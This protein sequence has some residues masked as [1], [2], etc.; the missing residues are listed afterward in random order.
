[1]NKKAF[2]LIEL[3]AVIV[4][5]AIIL[6]IAIPA[7]SSI[8]EN[9]RYAAFVQ[10]KSNIVSAAKLYAST[11]EEELPKNIGER[12]FINLQKL[13]DANLVTNSIVDTRTG[14]TITDGDIAVEKISPL[15]FKYTFI[16]S[17]IIKQGLVLWLEGRDFRNNPATSSWEDLTGLGN[18]ASPVNVAFDSASGSDG[19]G[20]VVFDGNNDYASIPY[21]ANM[22]PTYELTLEIKAKLFANCTTNEANYI[23]KNGYSNYRIGVTTTGYIHTTVTARNSVGATTYIDD[24]GTVYYPPKNTTFHATYVYDGPNG[25]SKLYVN[26]VL[27]SQ[28]SIEANMPILNSM[29]PIL[30]GRMTGYETVKGSVATVRIYNKALTS[31]QVLQNYNA[32]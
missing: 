13:R 23:D 10:T 22:N 9:S 12:T 16:P 2:T 31:E 25:L 6:A 4:V 18:H 15:E 32:S 14:Q 27:F 8:I 1:M 3:L 19:N 21:K 20:Y 7:I 17:N 28:K 11:H 26:G 30:I 24:Y 29:T 5:L